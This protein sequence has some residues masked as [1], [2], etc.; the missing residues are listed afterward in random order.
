MREVRDE[1]ES[2]YIKYCLE[3]Y[4]GNVAK[5]F[6]VLQIERTYLYKKLKNMDSDNLKK[7]IFAR[8]LGW[9]STKKILELID[10]IYP[11]PS[12]HGYNNPGNNYARNQLLNE[13]TNRIPAAA[14]CPHHHVFFCMKNRWEVYL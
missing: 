7:N 10:F 8:L 6:E 13:N 11:S 9:H 3:K 2:D 12:L 1:I 5:L 4:D 14:T